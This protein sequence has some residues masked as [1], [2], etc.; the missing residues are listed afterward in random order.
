MPLLPPPHKNVQHYQ[1]NALSLQVSWRKYKKHLRLVCNCAVCE[2]FDPQR[3]SCS[4]QECD[5]WCRCPWVVVG[6]LWL[7]RNL[8][9]KV[10]HWCVDICGTDSMTCLWLDHASQSHCQHCKKTIDK[11]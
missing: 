10:E 8:K 6:R 9:A 7:W 4:G 3:T 1:I 11:R 2:L 5:N